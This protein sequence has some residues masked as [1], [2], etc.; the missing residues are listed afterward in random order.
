MLSIGVLLACAPV[1]HP[2][3]PLVVPVVVVPRLEEPEARAPTPG[4]TW[5]ALAH[6]HLDAGEVGMAELCEGK[7]AELQLWDASLSNRLGLAA[8]DAGDTA[9]AVGR[10]QEALRLEADHVDANLNLGALALEAGDVEHAA[11]RFA[12]VWRSDAD[13]R[14]AGLG[15]AHAL[16]MDGQD[17][18]AV[19]T[20]LLELDPEDWAAAEAAALHAGR[21]GAWAVG[22]TTLDAYMAA[23]LAPDPDAFVLRDRLK[24]EAD[25][26]AEQ[27]RLMR[28]FREKEASQQEQYEEW[29]QE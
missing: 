17:P 18:V 16:S 27:E 29:L 7:A 9:G 28:R 26:E 15:L 6:R 4:E 21:T 11:E 13:H 8:L 22:L 1:K 12:V 19:Y 25:A 24:D 2:I 3:E 10:F 5:I 23:S 20:R 14:D